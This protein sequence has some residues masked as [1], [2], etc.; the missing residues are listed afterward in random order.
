MLAF[1][2][3]IVYFSMEHSFLVHGNV[4]HLCALIFSV[5][6]S[7]CLLEILHDMCVHVVSSLV[8]TALNLDAQAWITTSLFL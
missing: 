7:N 5:I 6:L 4:L 8:V 3:Y 1:D 2:F